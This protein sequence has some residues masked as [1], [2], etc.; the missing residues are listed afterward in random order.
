MF[1]EVISHIKQIREGLASL[2]GDALQSRENVITGL[3]RVN[4]SRGQLSTGEPVRPDYSPGYASYKGFTT[5][6][7]KDTGGFYRSLYVAIDKQSQAVQVRSD[8][9]RDGINLAEHL[10]T[11]YSE[12]IYGL[13]KTQGDQV[14]NDAA[15]DVI[16]LIDDGFKS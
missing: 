1:N 7:L 14:L 10:A 2:F 4:L 5:P 8:E 9:M 3:N 11:K 15:K 12:D 13:Q 16:K 6:D